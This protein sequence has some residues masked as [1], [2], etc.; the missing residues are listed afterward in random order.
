MILLM[1]TMNGL[2]IQDQLMTRV[3]SETV[4]YIK[5]MMEMHISYMTDRPETVGTEMMLTDVSIL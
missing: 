5:M 3:M 4:H 1:E 2:V